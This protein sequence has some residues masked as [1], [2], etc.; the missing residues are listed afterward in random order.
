[1]VEMILIGEV[2]LISKYGYWL[3]NTQLNPSQPSLKMEGVKSPLKS[4]FKFFFEKDT[5]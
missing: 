2:I 1:M 5:N 4:E 3:L